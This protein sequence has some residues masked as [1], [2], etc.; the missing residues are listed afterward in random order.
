[1][2]RRQKEKEEMMSKK[3][4]VDLHRKGQK[5]TQKEEDLLK[6]LYPDKFNFELVEIFGR[7]IGGIFG[8]AN[9]FGLTKKWRELGPSRFQD[10]KRWSEKELKRLKKLFP[11]MSIVQLQKH[12]PIRSKAAITKKALLL[13]LRKTYMKSSSPPE[14]AYLNL[15]RDQKEIL[16]KLYPTTS[17]KEI[18]KLL[19]RSVFAIKTQAQ[20]LGLHKVTYEPGVRN[21][22]GVKFWTKKEDALIRKLY[23][24]TYA[25]DIAA[26]LE[27]RDAKSIQTRAAFLGVKKDP[28]FKKPNNLWPD[29]DIQKLR[30]LW[31]QG[32]NRAEISEMIGR[33]LTSVKH[34]V[35]R[36]TREFDLPERQEGQQW[37]RKETACLLRHYKTKTSAELSIILGR[38]VSSIYNKAKRLNLTD[39]VSESKWSAS[40]ISRLK[41]NYKQGPI[42]RIAKKLCRSTRSVRRKA[43]SLGLLEEKQTSWTAKETSILKK[44]YKTLPKETIAEKLE[45]RT[46]EA[47][48]VKAIKLGL[49][50]RNSLM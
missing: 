9:Y 3:K 46:P 22:S 43:G 35:Q 12:F 2:S 32:Y 26:R 10:R 24:T 42:L 48:R 17:N 36:Q 11:I 27:E 15:L 5:W 50:K 8:K 21:G 47:V 44:Y 25:K 4:K 13:G 23:P 1:V 14:K 49:R 37:S 7:T 41:K 31:Q 20:K 19:G 18:A 38:S 6:K 40:E 29:E 33:S 28:E 34:Q 39:E 30:N 16:I 45:N